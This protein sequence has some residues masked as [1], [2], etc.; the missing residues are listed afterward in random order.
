MG[1]IDKDKIKIWIE[2]ANTNPS[3]VT[4][5]IKGEISDFDKSGGDREVEYDPVIGGYS[6]RKQATSEH[7]MEFSLIFD[8]D[9][10]HRWDEMRYKTD[11]DELVEGDVDDKV[12]YI[13]YGEGADAHSYGF[14]NCHTVNLEHSF[15]GDSTVEGTINFSFPATTAEGLTNYKKKRGEIT[16]ISNWDNS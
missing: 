9:L 1:T 6:K 14:N 8:E 16:E 2:D 11:G 7:T 5:P 4:D 13:Q 12:I 15:S 3:G 10:M